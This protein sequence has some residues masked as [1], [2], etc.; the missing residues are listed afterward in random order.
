MDTTIFAALA[1]HLEQRYEL[2]P[3]T[4][5]EFVDASG[6]WVR[7][8]DAVARG[9]VCLARVVRVVWSDDD[10]A[11]SVVGVA[12]RL[13][14]G[15]VAGVARLVHVASACDATTIF[16]LPAGQAIE[17]EV[18]AGGAWRDGYV[19]RGQNRQSGVEHSTSASNDA[20]RSN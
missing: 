6:R 7:L 1:T 11:G 17:V 10:P 2:P 18:Y 16:E 4:D 3:A 13:V 5:L 12:A 20:E 9:D 8:S 14:V 19:V 15:D